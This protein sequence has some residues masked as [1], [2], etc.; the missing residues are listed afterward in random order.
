[1]LDTLPWMLEAK[2]N[3]SAEGIFSRRAAVNAEG[4][5]RKIGRMEWWM[6][7]IERLE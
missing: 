5:I 6:N 7:G 4:K 1:M 2:T 3:K